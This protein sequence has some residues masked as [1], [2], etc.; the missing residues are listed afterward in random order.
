MSDY[1]LEE[2]KSRFPALALLLGLIWAAG[3]G[4][5]WYFQPKADEAVSEWWLFFGR[6]HP[7]VVHL[8]IGLL[9]VVPVLE[10]LGRGKKGSAMRAAVPTILWLVVLSS[11]AAT[12]FGYLLMTGE[13]DESLLM[14]RHFWSGLIFGGLILLTLMVRLRGPGFIYS[15]LLIASLVVVSAAGHYGGALVHGPSYLA[16]HAPEPLKPM[17]MFGMGVEKPADPGAEEA[18]GGEEP[19]EDVPLTDK[20]VFND[21]VLPIMEAKCTEC[22]DANKTKGKLRLDTHEFI[23]AGS[24]GADYPNVEPGDSEASEL[25]YRVVL[26]S[27]DT[28]FMPPDGKDPM[29][30]EEIAVVR[31]WI[32]QGASA[33]ATVAELQADDAMTAKLLAI[34]AALAGDEEAAEAIAASAEPLSEW[35]LLTPEERDERM[36]EVLA[37]AE[38]YNFSVMPIS[39]EDDR[40]KV[41]VVNA[42][43]E[44]GD[45]QLATLEPVVEQVV[46]LDVGR[47]Q[48]SDEGMATVAKMRNLE[49]LHLENT[50]VTDGGIAKLAGLTRLEYLNLY[51]TEVTAAI[52]EPLANARNLRKLYLWQ[53]KVDPGEA[54]AFQRSMSLEVNIGTELAVAEP[55]E[56]E[57]KP[58]EAAKKPE[59][60][61]PAEEA[62]KEPAPKPKTEPAKTAAKPAEEKPKPKEVAKNDAP[63]KPEPTAKKNQPAPA[64]KEESPKPSQSAVAKKAEPEKPAPAKKPEEAPK[65]TAE[66]K[67]AAEKKPDPKPEAKPEAKP[68]PEA[69]DKPAPAEAEKKP[70]A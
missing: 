41:N 12:V 39:A 45:E 31:W 58:E 34:D 22:H 69:K 30:P 8:P 23:M 21:F 65:K 67:P 48:I 60:A 14:E 61:K 17:M 32:D 3:L 54:R 38:H 4:A 56:P 57:A 55:A 33:E 46:W 13:P 52:F 50:K 36:K 27:D 59:P 43:K 53:T 18:V 29:T 62:K 66:A 6:F 11:V 70:A 25:I 20:V 2:K 42:S 68:A 5:L 44:F 47:S 35:D 37:A 1:P 63:A 49:R 40:L 10:I 19:A 51:G 26:P 16:K 28:D 24:E 7:L 9:V 64:K 15:V